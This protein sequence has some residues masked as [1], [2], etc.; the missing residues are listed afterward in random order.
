M[1]D[2]VN[3]RPDSPE[4]RR[5]VLR[6][7]L[8]LS[9]Q[10]DLP[11]PSHISFQGSTTFGLLLDLQM[12]DNDSAGVDRWTEVLANGPITSR[13]IGKTPERTFV[14]YRS[15][16]WSSDGPTWLGLARVDIWSALDL[17]DGGEQS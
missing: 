3:P 16:R 11:M 2:Q 1:T 12:G 10:H 15:D 4:F 9:K 14:N 7:L 13:V 17:T 5:E 6:T 8:E